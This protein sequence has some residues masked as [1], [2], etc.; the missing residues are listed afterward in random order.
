MLKDIKITRSEHPSAPII[1]ST[2]KDVGRSYKIML[3]ESIADI[4][5]YGAMINTLDTATEKD[6]ITIVINTPGGFVHTG[7]AIISAMERCKAPITTVATGL[8]ASCGFMIFIYGDVLK[9]SEFARI[10][11]HTARGGSVGTMRDMQEYTK[12]FEVM[13]ADLIKIA[14]DKKILTQEEFDAI[15]NDSQDVWLSCG[16]FDTKGVDYIK[17]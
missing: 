15:F 16:D 13:V 4:G 2:A 3:H 6:D 14:I 5:L 10:M 12:M 7:L 1:T 9:V 8:V 11:A 17:C